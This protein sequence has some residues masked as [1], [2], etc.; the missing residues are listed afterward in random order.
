MKSA[1]FFPLAF[2]IE[3]NPKGLLLFLVSHQNADKPHSFCVVHRE[4]SAMS[5]SV[6]VFVALFAFGVLWNKTVQILYLKY[7][8]RTSLLMYIFVICTVCVLSHVLN[9]L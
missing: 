5:S 7:L 6:P 4:L 3:T 1:F 2:K 9:I 8:K